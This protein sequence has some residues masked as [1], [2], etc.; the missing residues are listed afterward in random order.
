MTNIVN[1]KNGWRSRHAA[2]KRRKML[3]QVAPGEVDLLRELEKV[4][5]SSD[6]IAEQQ[7]QRLTPNLWSFDSDVTGPL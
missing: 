5:S 6:A 7:D 2:H 4:T 1:P 3:W